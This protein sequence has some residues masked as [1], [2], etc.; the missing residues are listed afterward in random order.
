MNDRENKVKVLVDK[1]VYGTTS[2]AFHPMQNDALTEISTE[3]F[4]KYMDMIGR[5]P[6][7]VD[8]LSLKKGTFRPPIIPSLAIELEAAKKA[9]KKREAMKRQHGAEE[10]YRLEDHA[11]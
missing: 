2:V 7:T 6:V 8:F 4:R 5:S 3:D 1:R 10:E 9:H 11:G